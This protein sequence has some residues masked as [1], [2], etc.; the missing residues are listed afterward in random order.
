MNGT[1]ITGI[2]ITEAAMTRAIINRTTAEGAMITKNA[3]IT[4]GAMITKNAMIT[5]GAM[6]TKGAI[7]GMITEA[8]ITNADDRDTAAS[9]FLRK[10]L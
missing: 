6:I 9:F 8:T 4:E 7:N 1:A 2:T 3:M 10:F 5:E